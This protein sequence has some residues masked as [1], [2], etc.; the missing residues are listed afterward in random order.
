[1]PLSHVRWTTTIAAA[2]LIAL[3]LVASA[4]TQTPPTQTPPTQTPPT[5]QAEP[6]TP[7]AQQPSAQQTPPS[8]EAQSAAQPDVAV[9]KKHLSEARDALSQLT[10]LPEATKLQGQARTEVSQLISNFNALISAQTDWRSAYDKVN[11]NLITLLG[12]EAADQPVGTSGSTAEGAV[13]IDPAIRTK[14]AEFRTHLKEFEKAAGAPASSAAPPSA[15]ATSGSMPPSAATGTTA[16][17]ANPTAAGTPANPDPT[18]PNQAPT[19]AGA[20]G[21]SG[22]TPSSSPT[23]S[24]APMDRDTA[25]AAINNA[26]AAKEL[27]AISAILDK[28]TTGALTKAQTV[29]LKKHVE[30]LRAL[31]KPGN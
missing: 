24:M 11:A 15:A 14:L 9:A 22:V 30:Q 10:T 21:T 25:A 18:K 31:L 6:Q 3:P 7:P 29:E 4:S 28:S 26:E 17:P 13:Q 19:A 20:T 1:M 27:D 23:T 16:N 5:Q 2:A 12:P 8:A